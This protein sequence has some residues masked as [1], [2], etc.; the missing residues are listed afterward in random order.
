MSFGGAWHMLERAWAPRCIE[1]CS[2]KSQGK[3]IEKSVS[4][5]PLMWLFYIGYMFCF[6]LV[7]ALYYLLLIGLYL[8]I[9]SILLAIFLVLIILPGYFCFL[10][11]MIRK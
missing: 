11:I 4:N 7:A 6:I 2:P 10:V 9:S 5:K 3:Y 8:T 1:S